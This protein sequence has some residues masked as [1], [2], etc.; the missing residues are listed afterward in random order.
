MKKYFALI[1]VTFLFIPFL[2][3][4][5]A[6]NG[7]YSWENPEDFK[8]V[9]DPSGTGGGIRGTTKP[10]SVSA[11]VSLDKTLQKDYYLGSHMP[12]YANCARYEGCDFTSKYSEYL[13][14]DESSSTIPYDINSAVFDKDIFGGDKLRLN[15]ISDKDNWIKVWNGTTTIEMLKN[16]VPKLGD[17]FY[18]IGNMS[19]NIL[20]REEFLHWY[21]TG[22]S[23]TFQTDKYGKY[24]HGQKN[25]LAE[26]SY[27]NAING[28]S[29]N[30]KIKK[31]LG[32]VD[33]N[34]FKCGNVANTIPITSPLKS[35]KDYWL[36]KKDNNGKIVLEWQKGEY[37]LDNGITKTITK[38][39][40]YPSVSS[41]LFSS[42]EKDT[43]LGTTTQINSSSTDLIASTTNTISV[44]DFATSTN[45]IKHGVFYNIWSWVVSLF[46]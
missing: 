2:V 37:T 22:S 11:V 29:L 13:F 40:S 24:I 28:N 18:V 6:Y 41:F 14:I 17:P 7:P 8:N 36:F 9:E 25:G 23:V 10:I 15:I 3:S 35:V 16:L 1:G 44:V 30:D 21:E 20:D 39:D 27:V 46:K 12:L 38:D 42:K 33:T 26:F 32:I 45:D 43:Q 4:A 5:D 34:C 19:E 31:D